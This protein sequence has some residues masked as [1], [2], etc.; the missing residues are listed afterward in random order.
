MKAGLDRDVPQQMIG[1]DIEIGNRDR[2]ASGRRLT[3]QAFFFIDREMLPLDRFVD[4]VGFDQIELMLGCVIAVDQH[5]V[6]VSNLQRAGRNRRQHGIE[7]ERGGDRAAD[8]FK[9]FQLVDRLREV[10]GALFHLGFEAGIGLLELAGHA[11]ELVGEFFQL[12]LGADVDAVTEI[13]GAEPPRAGAQRRDRDQHPACQQ[14]AGKDR[15]HK[16]EPDQ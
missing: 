13:A 16:P 9:H 5:R 11:V 3:E 6:G 2:L 14:R 8:L 4:A 12:V 15:N 1:G 10:A 7:I